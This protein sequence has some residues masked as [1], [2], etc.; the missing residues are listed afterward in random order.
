[1]V[2][3]P[4]YK[5]WF[6]TGPQSVGQH[7]P[8][9]LFAMIS[10][11]L[12]FLGTRI[13]SITAA[14]DPQGPIRGQSQDEADRKSIGCI[15]CHSSSD[16]PTMHPS[17]AVHLGCTDCHGGN[18][19]TA[20]ASS[21]KSGSPEYIAIKEKAH[22]QPRDPLF[23]NRSAIP[24]RVYTK[25]LNEPAEYIKFVNPGDLRVAAETCG[26][27]GCH[28]SETRAVSTNMM[29][30][31]GFLWGAALYNN[32]GIPFKNA[33]FGE[34]Y[35]RD[36]LPQSLKTIPPPTP[37]ETRS[38][39]VLPELMPLYRWETSQPGNIL[40]VFEQ[41]GGDKALAGKMLGISRATLYRKLKRYNIGMKAVELPHLPQLE[42]DVR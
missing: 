13:P 5:R 28:P 36:G 4:D 23:K 15:T 27:A 3:F 38:K 19:T 8:V 16:E 18:S 2:G 40:R 7:L 29:T 14:D 37:E 9:F 22:V 26:S 12:L 34:S 17:K 33:R 6:R 42:E 24:E 39:G 10:F 35:D 41:A 1:M 31:A 25:W 20:L 32:G 21:A 11:C 30:H